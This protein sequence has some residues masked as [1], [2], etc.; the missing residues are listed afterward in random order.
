ML[1]HGPNFAR[2]NTINTTVT[3][4]DAPDERYPVVEFEYPASE[5]EIGEMKV[6]YVRVTEATPRHIKGYELVTPLSKETGSSKTY[7]RTRMVRNGVFL[8]SF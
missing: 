1:T 3:K 6:R 4:T 8:L 5:N 7:L 2:M